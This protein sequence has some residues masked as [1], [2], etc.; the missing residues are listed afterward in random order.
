MEARPNPLDDLVLDFL[1]SKRRE[2]ADLDFKFTLDISRVSDFVEI[3]KDFFAMANFGG[4]YILF[5]FF[6]KE[7]GSYELLGLTKN[8]HVDQA[9][10]QEKFNSFSN[11]PITL[12]YREFE[13]DIEGT[14]KKFATIYVPPSTLILKPSKD[15]VYTDK[16]GRI[17][18]VFSK[19]DIFIRRGTQSIKASFDEM[20]YIEK[21]ALEEQKLAI[22]SGEPDVINENLFSNIFFVSRIPDKIH[23]FKVKDEQMFN[24]QAIDSDLAYYKPNDVVYT[25]S[26]IIDEKIRNN[27]D[28][29]SYKTL[30]TID[31][32]KD[33]RINIVTALLNKEIYLYNRNKGL[34]FDIRNRQVFYYPT[35]KNVLR[36]TWQSRYKKSTRIMAQRMYISALKQNVFWHHGAEMRFIHIGDDYFL[37]ILPKI[38]LTRDGYRAIHGFR[39]GTVITRLSY[40]EFNDKYLNHILFWRNYLNPKNN[41]EIVVN[42]KIFIDSEP[43]STSISLGIKSDRPSTEF[44]DRKS[45]LYFIEEVLQ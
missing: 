25:F 40:N 9:S 34:A 18:R 36:K 43:V 44:K 1:L 15:G 14:E 29:H 42:E 21:R 16:K 22:L 37:I 3:A 5:G 23:C 31:L 2:T 20:K 28:K 35:R 41:P 7:T 11:E 24:Y 4:G 26:E 10:L 45:E 30:S 19:G 17:R 12:H 38:V 13:R 39:E 33:G 32:L 27:I 8:F 6:E